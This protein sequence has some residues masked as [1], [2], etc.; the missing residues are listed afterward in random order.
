MKACSARQEAIVDVLLDAN[1]DVNKARQ[2]G[3]TAL[4]Y[5]AEQGALEIVRKLVDRGAVIDGADKYVRNT[6]HPL[7]LLLMMPFHCTGNDSVNK[8]LRGQAFG[9]CFVSVGGRSK[10]KLEIGW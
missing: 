3:V 7:C 9:G 1:V 2:D 10:W 8:C 4:I 5:A 6:A